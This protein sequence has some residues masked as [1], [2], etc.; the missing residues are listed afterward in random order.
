[1]ITKLVRNFMTTMLAKIQHLCIF[2]LRVTRVLIQF[3]LLSK[4]LDRAWEMRFFELVNVKI[5]PCVEY[6]SWA[7]YCDDHTHQNSAFL[8]ES[9]ERYKN[10]SECRLAARTVRQFS[11]IQIFERTDMEVAVESNTHFEV[12]GIPPLLM[13]NERSFRD[14]TVGSKIFHVMCCCNCLKN[15]HE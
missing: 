2:L 1:L 15:L 6:K 14:W 10:F 9:T 3:W 12:H 8:Q 7:K 11:A 13:Q 4:Q 5:L